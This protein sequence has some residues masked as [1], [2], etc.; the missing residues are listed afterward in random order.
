MPAG[1]GRSPSARSR[2]S[3]AT[4]AE[5]GLEP[6]ESLDERLEARVQASQRPRLV[7]GHGRRVARAPAVGGQRLVQRLGAAG[8]RLAVLR[9]DQPRADLVGLAGPQPRVGDLG[10]LVLED[11]EPARDLARIER[12][13]LERRPVVAPRATAAA[14]ASRMASC[15]PNASSRSRCQRSS[16]SRPWSCWPW[17]STSGPTSSA[18]RAAVTVASSRRAV[19]RPAAVTSRTAMSGS[20]VRS[21]RA[22][23][24]ADS[25][26][27]RTS[28]VSA[29]APSAS[30]RASMSRLLPAPVSPVMTLNPGSN[31]SRSR[32]ISARSWTVSSSRRPG[33][34]AGRGWS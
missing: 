2:A 10:R 14:M 8:D 21:N 7:E 27:W 5:L 11:V 31:A 6:S 28:V 34:S 32:S 16:S 25:A 26:P 12:R 13:R 19:E 20:G 33:R 9:R 3:S 22:S 1:R 17:I 23:T 15:P 24:R 30:P 4:S 18:S 29:R